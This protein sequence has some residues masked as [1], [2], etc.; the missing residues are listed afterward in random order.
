MVLQARHYTTRGRFL[1]GIGEGYWAWGVQDLAVNR[2]KADGI[3]INPDV[4]KTHVAPG[5]SW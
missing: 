5:E 2:I 4:A 1:Y 3:E